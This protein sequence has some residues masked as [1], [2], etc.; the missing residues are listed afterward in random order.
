MRSAIWSF[1]TGG[2]DAS[3]F[4][5]VL[6]PPCNVQVE[7]YSSRQLEIKR[8]DYPYLMMKYEVTNQLYADYLNSALSAGLVSLADN[9]RQVNGY[10]HTVDT[11][12]ILGLYDVM[13]NVFEWVNFGSVYPGD[14][15]PRFAYGISFS[16]N[17]YY[18]N[19]GQPSIFIFSHTADDV[20]FRCVKDFN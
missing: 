12:S 14:L 18:M 5:W 8:I 7:N 15:S 17:R 9:Y 11:P 4:N 20:G 6:I 13:G 16:G 19:L 10:F 1:T 2:P 3:G